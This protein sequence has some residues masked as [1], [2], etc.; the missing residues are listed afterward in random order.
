MGRKMAHP[1]LKCGGA[2]MNAER[3]RAIARH[4]RELL[5]VARQPEIKEQLREWEQ[6]TETEAE[7]T[8]RSY[9]QPEHR[10]KA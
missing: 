7:T 2:R 6:E 4:C 10:R 5:R 9:H 8:E 3:L 1:A